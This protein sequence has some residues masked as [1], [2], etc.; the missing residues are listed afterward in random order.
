MMLLG[1]MYGN[2]GH[3]FLDVLRESQLTTCDDSIN[4]EQILKLESAG[5]Y[6]QNGM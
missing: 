2:G 6:G 1:F 4:G 5:R 3:S